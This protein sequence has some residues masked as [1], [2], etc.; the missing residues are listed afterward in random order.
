MKRWIPKVGET[1][2]LAGFTD[3]GDFLVEEWSGRVEKVSKLD[4]RRG[5]VWLRIAGAG[6][7]EARKEEITIH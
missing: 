2:T 4:T 5:R 1:V 3:A 6:T 7:T